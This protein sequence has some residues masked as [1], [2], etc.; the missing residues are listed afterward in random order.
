MSD[1]SIQGEIV[2]SAEKAE[3]GFDRV[4][5]LA[6]RMASAVAT[7]AGKAGSA[8]DGIGD[9]ADAGAD[10]FTRAEARMRAA[11]QRSTQELQLLGKAASEKLSFQID[12]K[13]LDAAKFAPYLAELKAV[14][15]AQGS[16]GK[17]AQ[18]SATAVVAA[19]SSIGMSAKQTAAAMRTVPAQ[20]TDIVVSLQAGQA[21]MQVLLQQG[22]QLKDMF[23][24]VGAAAKALGSYVL[25][26]VNPFTLAAAAAV[27]LGVAYYQ[28][29]Q[30]SSGFSRAL[31][32]TGNAAGETVDS[33][34]SMADAIAAT[35]RSRGAAVEALTEIANQGLAAGANLQS[36]AQVAIDMERT[37]G[38]AIGK[39]VGQLADLG[40]EPVAA[41]AKLNKEYGYL[42][43]SVYEQIKALQDQGKHTDAARLAQEAFTTSMAQRT[44]QVV[45]NAGLMKRAWDDVK[46]AVSGALAALQGIGRAQGKSDE[47]ADVSAQ[48]ERM[49]KNRLSAGSFGQ[50]Q[51]GQQQDNS[52]ALAA[53]RQ[54][55]ALLQEDIRLSARAAEADATRQR[56]EKAGVAAIDAVSK[57]NESAAT[58]TEKLNKA[59]GDYRRNLDAIR[60]ANPNSELLDPKKIAQTEAGIRDQYKEKGGA[61]GSK[62][63]VET[64]ENEVARIRALIQEEERY[65]QSLQERGVAAEKATA[66]EK[67]VLQIQEQLA[68][69]IK[70]VA[71]A[72]KEAALAEAEKLVAAEKA[73]SSAE[74]QAKAIEEARQ[75]TERQVSGA[76]KQAEDID[77]QAADLERS[78][79]LFGKG[80]IAVEEYKLEQMQAMAAMADASDSFVPDYVRALNEM[81]KAQQRLTDATREGEYLA[82]RKKTQDRGAQVREQARLYEDEAR[83]AGM[84]AVQR[85]KIVA[86]RQVELDLAKR[87]KEIEASGLSDDKKRELIDE[88][89]ANAAMARSNAAARVV[90]EDWQ[91]T[92]DS[93]N[94]SLTDALLR[95][96]EDGKG[97]GKNFADTLKN[98]F[99]TLVLRPVISFIIQPIGNAIS[100][101]LSGILGGGQ[102]GGILN[103]LFGSEGS[104]VDMGGLM[105][106]AGS[107]NNMWGLFSNWMGFGTGAGAGTLG[108]ANAVGMMG[109]DA[110]GTFIAANGGWG[111]T[112]VMGGGGGAGGI[113]GTAAGAAVVAVPLVIGALAERAS[114]ERIGGAAY[115]SSD[116]RKDPVAGAGSGTR[117]DAATGQLPEY[118]AMVDRLVELGYG[119]TQEWYAQFKGNDRALYM[120]M[121]L[122]ES[123]AAVGAESFRHVN[124][125]DMIDRYGD[126]YR[127][128]GAADP[129]AMG[130]WNW[131]GNEG[132][133]VDPAAIELSRNVAASIVGPLTSLSELIGGAADDLRVSVGYAQRGPGKGVWAGMRVE[134]NG[135]TVSDWTNTDDYHSVGEAVQGMYSH[136]LEVLTTE[137]DLPEWAA[138]QAAAARAELEALAGD[139]VAQDATALYQNA[140]ASIAKTYAAIQQLIDIFPNFSA[141]TQ[142]SVY[143]LAQA[144]GGM[145]NLSSA[146]GAYV[147]NFYSAGEQQAFVWGQIEDALAAVGLAVPT[148]RDG[149]RE[150]VDSLDLN[151]EAGRA[152]FAALMSVQG[153]FAGL[154]DAAGLAGDSLGMTADSIKGML[155]SILQEAQSADEARTM[156]EAAAGEMFMNAITSVMLDS[157]IGTIMSGM[158]D[159][160]VAQITAGAA[161]AAAIDVA[162]ATASASTMAVGGTVAAGTMAA[163]GSSAAGSMAAGGAAAGNHL[164]A[165]VGQVVST[166]NS[167]TSVFSS[168]EFRDA[169]QSFTEGMGE[170]SASLFT[171]IGAIGT[172][173]GTGNSGNFSG[174]GGGS[175]S[176]G[177]A[178]DVDD[179]AEALKRL[180]K[181]VAEEVNRLRGLNTEASEYGL[182]YLQSQFATSTAQARAGDLTA[183]GKLP[184]LSKAIEDMTK[185]TTL[186]DMENVRMRAW[187]ANSLEG[188]LNT[189]GLKLEDFDDPDKLKLSSTGLSNPPPS[190]TAD[191]AASIRTVTISGSADLLVELRTLNARVI[192]LEKALKET[193]QNT[194]GLPQLVDQF[195]NATEGGNAM[196]TEVMNP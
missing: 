76:H 196:R 26:M 78:N 119:Q 175:P 3:A 32:M 67:L 55:Q 49:Q 188:T 100:G 141:A 34:T 116:P 62:T 70:G 68:G 132:A 74:K 183:L 39:T 166:M 114:R 193:Q 182:A 164:S 7:A 144:M 30:E 126:F 163:G 83:L 95:G 51:E 57:A 60:A 140:T 109:G 99:K 129:Q 59:L 134:R 184:E 92:A 104:G 53:L 24:G 31:V 85:A 185:A 146:H 29:S 81:V 45:Q 89:T 21:P 122:V 54:R 194:A 195:D 40:N 80:K 190:T 147:S 131:K 128:A 52:A 178:N 154:T 180:G 105:Q 108:L 148:T 66:G 192:E 93:I 35:G 43:A 149:F 2:V 159:P 15:A 9:Q 145:D 16:V 101:V 47:L 88:E 36:F 13:G 136:A 157:V 33:L 18:A 1:L 172:A 17:A 179:L 44:S 112:G 110:M 10:K 65:T 153:A 103:T 69:G 152:A 8:V 75:A 50:F 186:G 46:G 63:G 189:L 11:I 72:N 161:Q 155:T 170:I 77:K 111:T 162:G 118:Q 6:T 125:Q 19:Q 38:Q 20:M 71:R 98:M 121:Q 73:R 4:E 173:V 41:S 37:T 48:I 176:G 23:G 177:A 115:A 135:E 106:S 28:G 27:A 123:Q 191:V 79:A 150:L 120:L 94:S 117:Y 58:K 113:S 96:F 137:F 151:T 61:K 187:L 143:A 168:S 127:G 14:E 160:L 25:G 138:Q 82:Q 84:T 64:G 130:W 12:A 87:I 156:G 142:D 42:T 174:G 181:T 158:V 56:V 139:N 5:D 102:G 167:M 169:Y 124:P 171:N 90:Q 107:L 165:V 97:F 22:G 133:S 86:E 91:K